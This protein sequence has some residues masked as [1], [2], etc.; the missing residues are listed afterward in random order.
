MRL[1]NSTSHNQR[2][3]IHLSEYLRALRGFILNQVNLLMSGSKLILAPSPRLTRRARALYC[4][5]TNPSHSAVHSRASLPQC[6][7]EHSP[8]PAKQNYLSSSGLISASKTASEIECSC[9]S[10]SAEM[11]GWHDPTCRLIRPTFASFRRLDFA[12]GRVHLSDVYTKTYSVCSWESSRHLLSHL[13]R[14]RPLCSSLK[15]RN[16]SNPAQRRHVMP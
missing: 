3:L 12:E 7:P 5:V 2:L 13:S 11:P 9:A 4:Q 16:K 15:S 8:L 6:K 10:T 14:S 1:S